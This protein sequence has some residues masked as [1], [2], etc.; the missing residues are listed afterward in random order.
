MDSSEVLHYSLLFT[1]LICCTLCGELQLEGNTDW[2][3]KLH[4][5]TCM[6]LSVSSE[7]FTPLLLITVEWD[8]FPLRDTDLQQSRCQHCHHWG[9]THPTYK[10]THW[11]NVCTVTVDDCS[12]GESDNKRHRLRQK[13]EK[14]WNVMKSQIKIQAVRKLSASDKINFLQPV[15]WWDVPSWLI[16]ANTQTQISNFIHGKVRGLRYM[17]CIRLRY[18]LNKCSNAHISCKLFKGKFET[19]DSRY[20]AKILF[21]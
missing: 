13:H 14:T 21:Y 12:T 9:N 20:Y 17:S 11:N 16:F 7:D 10:Q 8:R 1:L 15:Q 19:S 2:R 6:M 4:C 5:S 18:I 3:Y